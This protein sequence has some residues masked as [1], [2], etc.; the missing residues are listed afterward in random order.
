MIA[1]GVI[2]AIMIE[3]AFPHFNLVVTG[4]A[5]TQAVIESVRR[6]PF[7][8][9]QQLSLLLCKFLAIAIERLLE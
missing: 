5:L 4:D 7:Q 1:L 8:P 6:A 2:A 9:G 3:G